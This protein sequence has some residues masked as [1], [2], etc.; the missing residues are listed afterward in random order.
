MKESGLRYAV[1]ALQP[2]DPEVGLTAYFTGSYLDYPSSSLDRL[3]VDGGVSK[4]L[5]GPDGPRLR[6][7]IEAGTFEFNFDE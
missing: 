5:G 2:I 4:E 3:T 1:Q 7:G 6:G